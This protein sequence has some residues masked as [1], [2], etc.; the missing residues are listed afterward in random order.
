MSGPDATPYRQARI[1]ALFEAYTEM[2]SASADALR[3]HF[4][5]NFTGYAG[6]S[7]F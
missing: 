3:A 2:H 1:R 5:D 6:C 4:S 7:D